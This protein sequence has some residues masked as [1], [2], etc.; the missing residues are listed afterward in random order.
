MGDSV[1]RRL[2]VE[3]RAAEG[4]RRSWHTVNAQEAGRAF[5]DL[6]AL[7]PGGGLEPTVENREALRY[8]SAL[9]GYEAGEMIDQTELVFD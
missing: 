7:R 9:R 6:V 8:T 4:A 5:G 2:L 3:R 1:Q